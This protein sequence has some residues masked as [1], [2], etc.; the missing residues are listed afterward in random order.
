MNYTLIFGSFFLI[1]FILSEIQN[2]SRIING[3]LF[4]MS[5]S[6]YYLAIVF[7][8]PRS[9]S[10]WILLVT[11]LLIFL[12]FVAFIV[13]MIHNGMVMMRREKRRLSNMLSLLMGAGIIGMIVLI[14]VC[15]V[16]STVY[17]Q[18]SFIITGL[19]TCFMITMFVLFLMFNF[20]ISAVV[21]RYL[22]TRYNKDFI[23]IL[24]AGLLRGDQVSPLLAS[25]LDKGLDFYNRQVKKKGKRAKIIV[26][27]GQGKGEEISEAE[28]MADYLISK[29]CPKED[30]LMENKSRNTF[31][32]LLF[33]KAIMEQYGGKKNS[34]FVTNNYHVFRASIL[35]RKVKIKRTK[36]IGSK[37]AFYY[38]PSAFIREFIGVIAIRK[39]RYISIV[40]IIAGIYIF[41]LVM[42]YLSRR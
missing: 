2:P 41:S 3:F 40:A 7:M 38:V 28:A 9:V 19:T 18:V 42:F 13:Y 16:I 22:P 30:I 27:G 4:F 14:I 8:L 12:A 10:G 23:I 29:G 39:W 37:T 32:N 36:G 20:L 34:I 11:M 15:A 31:E 1:L 5:F 6:I 25:R 17:P 35:A 21:Y 26:S 33:S 24:G